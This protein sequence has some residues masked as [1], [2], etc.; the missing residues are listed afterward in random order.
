MSDDKEG[1]EGQELGIEVEVVGSARVDCVLP[2]DHR[3]CEVLCVM[4][5]RLVNRS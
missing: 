2:D 1:L 5:I 3:V 4:V